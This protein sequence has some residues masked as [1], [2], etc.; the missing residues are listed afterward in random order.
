LSNFK[1]KYKIE[2]NTSAYKKL[3]GIKKDKPN[4][5]NSRIVDKDGNL[6]MTTY[7]SGVWIY[8][9]K[10]LSNLEIKNDS[11]DVLLICI[12]LDKNGII[13]LGTDNDGVYKQN[14][15]NF[16]IYVVKI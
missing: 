4:Y 9:G 8:G 5:F 2:A 1:S 3:R 6:S 16:E 14:G 11:E 10:V 12:Y 15:D 7:G 13:W